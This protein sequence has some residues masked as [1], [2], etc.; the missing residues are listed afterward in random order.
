MFEWTKDHAIGLPQVDAQHQ[1]IFRMARELYDEMSTGGGSDAAKRI[2][3]RVVQY[4]EHHFAAEERLMRQYHYPELDAHLQQH[5]EFA[6]RVLEFQADFQA[7]RTMLTVEM[8][9]LL[10]DWLEVHIKESDR[11]YAEFIRAKAA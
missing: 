10:R 4:T 3:Q 11:G 2:L 7:G 9:R 5:Q 8:F 6:R 1:A